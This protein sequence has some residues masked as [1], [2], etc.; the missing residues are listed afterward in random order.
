VITDTPTLDLAAFERATGWAV[1]AEGACKDVRCV[2]LPP[3]ATDGGRI[4]LRSAADR[5]GMP[6]LHDEDAGLWAL[7]PEAAGVAL[8]TA[9]APDVVFPTLDGEPY[10]LSR[11]RG[12]KVLLHAWASW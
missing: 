5:L 8:S 9:E 11:L 7:G 2:P 3:G 6:L 10:P 1:K 4:D 12:R